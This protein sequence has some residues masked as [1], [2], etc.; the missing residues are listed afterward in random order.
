MLNQLNLFDCLA[1]FNTQDF[2][3][4]MERFESEVIEKSHL[5]VTQSLGEKPDPAKNSTEL[6]ANEILN[7]K[8]NLESDHR[9]SPITDRKINPATSNSADRIVQ[10]LKTN[11][12]NEAMKLMESSPIDFNAENLVDLHNSMVI[13]GSKKKEKEIAAVKDLVEKTIIKNVNVLE[14]SERLEVYACTG[15]C[16]AL[17]KLLSSFPDIDSSQAL[18]CAVVADQ[19]EAVKLLMKKNKDLPTDFAVQQ[20]IIAGNIDMLKIL[21]QNPEYDLEKIYPLKTA[22]TKGYVKIAELLLKD[23]RI[24]LTPESSG[25]QDACLYGHSKVVQLLLSD[26]RLRELEI[27]RKGFLDLKMYFKPEIVALLENHPGIK[28]KKNNMIK[29]KDTYPRL[30]KIYEQLLA[31]KWIVEKGD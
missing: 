12:I 17:K 7:V 25:L 14:P 26:S 3:V 11:R 13:L 4:F 30:R 1:T 6:I 19:K 16:E 10:A 5:L 24:K 8:A 28:I 29:E 21:I 15:N 18:N 2:M 23:E 31:L 20:S 27:D 22:A 9:L